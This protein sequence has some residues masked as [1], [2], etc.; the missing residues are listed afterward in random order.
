MNSRMNGMSADMIQSLSKLEQDAKVELWE[1]DLRSKGGQMHR[2][3]N[4]V[5]ELDGAVVWQ[6]K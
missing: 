2:F 3:C 5:N 1:I 6:G 4:Q